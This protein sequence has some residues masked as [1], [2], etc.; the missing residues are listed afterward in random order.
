MTETREHAIIRSF[1]ALS[2]SLVDDF[3]VLDVVT[4]LT[5][6]CARLLDVA[7]AG[8]LLADAR[9]E[10]HLLAA[11]SEQARSL[12]VF[13]LQRE[14]GPCRDCYQSGRP[15]N[16][17]DLNAE[18]DRWPQFVPAASREGFASVHA[19][20]MRLK[21]ER[22]GTL[23]LFGST[24]GDLNPEDLNLA[25]SLA[26]VATIAIVQENHAITTAT[27]APRLQAALASRATWET[28]KGVLA[29]VHGLDMD[30]ASA[31]LR[32]YARQHGQHLT[33]VAYATVYGPPADRSALLAQ[34]AAKAPAP[35]PNADAAS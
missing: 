21:Q 25:Q 8:L 13:Q 19:I 26:H 32:R 34:L 12:E 2:D 31:R 29:E 7:A 30:E 4:R 22:L 23:G 5:Q 14:E 33:D 27:L 6:D 10:L 24:P 18:I 3:D 15:V 9:G 1:M 35:E 11:T 28:A 20:P 16:V 17:A